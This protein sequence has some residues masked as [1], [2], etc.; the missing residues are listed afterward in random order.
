MENV[1]LQLSKTGMGNAPEELEKLLMKNYL[2]SLLTE[3]FYPS[4]IT[5][6]AD[7]VKLACE[8]SEVLPELQQLN[9][10]GSVIL[11]CKTCLTFFSLL[12]KVQVGVIAT[13][14]DI[15]AVQKKT[16]KVLTIA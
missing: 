8:G 2:K 7:G 14:N 9:E 15:V 11:I 6:Y 5:L 4:F 13:M 12:D 10:K 16:A 3:E 1:V